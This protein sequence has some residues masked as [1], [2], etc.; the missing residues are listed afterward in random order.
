[1]IQE[2]YGYQKDQAEKEVV[3]WETRNNYRW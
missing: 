2:R 3:D 1:K